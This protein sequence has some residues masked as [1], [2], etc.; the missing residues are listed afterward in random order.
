[1]MI[2]PLIAHILISG[3][4][5]GPNFSPKISFRE[6][7]VVV[8]RA[9]SL[10]QKETLPASDR[11]SEIFR[12]IERALVGE[13]S[14]SIAKFFGRKVFL[15]LE[16]REDAYYSSNQ[17]LLILQNFFETHRIITFR[18][19]SMSDSGSSPYATGGGSMKVKNAR[20]LVRIY[21][22]LTMVDNRWVISQFNLY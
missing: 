22:A 18:I 16:D 12:E 3:M 14:K 21:I 8:A 1:M 13:D 4:L 6:P 9:E 19:S 2:N 17:A 10:N 20:E 15:G 7:T 5:I 11:P